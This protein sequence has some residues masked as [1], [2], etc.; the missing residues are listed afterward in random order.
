MSHDNLWLQDIGLDFF[1]GQNH[2]TVAVNLIT[3][4]DIF[5]EDS[6]ILYSSPLADGGMPPDNT[7]GNASMLLNPDSPHYCTA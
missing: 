5:S 4:M 1:V 2:T 6:H 3:N 7:A